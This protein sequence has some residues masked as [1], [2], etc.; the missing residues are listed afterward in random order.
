MGGGGGGTGGGLKR[1]ALSPACEFLHRRPPVGVGCHSLRSWH[2]GTSP[3]GLLWGRGV[4]R[5]SCTS[6]SPP[7][8]PALLPSL[9]L[10]APQM[11][12][13]SPWHLPG[14]RA[15]PES[16]CAREWHCSPGGRGGHFSSGLLPPLP[17][18]L[19]CS[20][21]REARLDVQ[22]SH[23]L[24]SSPKLKGSR[25]EKWKT[26]RWQELSCGDLTSPRHPDC[27]WGGGNGCPHS[28]KA[29][30]TKED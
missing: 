8:L 9:R 27:A 5:R 13:C 15:A 22:P 4:S 12:T 1:G 7:F 2:P 3:K 14:F 17:Q 20:L 29:A 26:K 10:P 6:F 23:S 30:A 28:P 24:T 18:G 19:H 16:L 11:Q 21:L 25:C